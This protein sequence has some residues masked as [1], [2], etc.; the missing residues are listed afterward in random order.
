MDFKRVQD[1]V[2]KKTV[3]IPSKQFK[4]IYRGQFS[5]AKGACDSRRA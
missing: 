1:A 4:A 2:K 5:K 3:T